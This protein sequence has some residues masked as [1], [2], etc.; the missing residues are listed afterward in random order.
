M[1]GPQILGY[2]SNISSP[3]NFRKPAEFITKPSN[4]KD[5][6]DGMKCIFRTT[7]TSPGPIRFQQKI[8]NEDSQKRHSLGSIISFGSSSGYGSCDSERSFMIESSSSSESV[9]QGS[10]RGLK[11]IFES[12]MNGPQSTKSKSKTSH[13]LWSH[14]DVRRGGADWKGRVS[15]LR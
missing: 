5:E 13:V 8:E 1:F 15:P 11:C 9:S 2:G 3:A 4:F 10:D 7:D 6:Q 12:E 14:G